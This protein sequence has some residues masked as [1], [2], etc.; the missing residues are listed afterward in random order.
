MQ[1]YL[2]NNKTFTNVKFAKESTLLFCWITDQN[3]RWS[4]PKLAVSWR[5]HSKVVLQRGQQSSTSEI[6]T[7][8]ISDRSDH[9]IKISL[10]VTVMTENENRN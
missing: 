4:Y 10:N 7:A 8:E 9:C 1:S 2:I 6:S 3:G 5:C